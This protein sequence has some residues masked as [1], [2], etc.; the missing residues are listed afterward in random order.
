MYGGYTNLHVLHENVVDKANSA[1]VHPEA[2]CTLFE[3]D[4]GVGRWWDAWEVDRKYGSGDMVHGRWN[5]NDA[6]TSVYVAPGYTC[7]VWEH[8]FS[9][10]TVTLYPGFHFGDGLG[11]NGL[12]DLSLIHI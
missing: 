8:R 12:H 9:G 1:E 2:P 10:K 11:W 6:A 5:L 3:H 4:R 7:T